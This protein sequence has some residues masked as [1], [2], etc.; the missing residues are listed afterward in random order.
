MGRE[1]EQLKQ[2]TKDFAV[3]IVRVCD[4]LPNKTGASVISRQVLRSGTS[5]AANYR[6]ACRSRSRREFVAKLGIVM[7][8]SDETVFWLELLR[9]ADI[10][11]GNKLVSLLDEANQLVAIFTASKRTAEASLSAGESTIDNQKSEMVLNR[12]EE[13]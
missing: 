11:S 3:R 10:V 5:L 7:E 4:A 8:E 9:D 6:A 1:A 13:P 12:G 2:R